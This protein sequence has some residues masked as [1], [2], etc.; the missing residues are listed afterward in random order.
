[1]LCKDKNISIFCLIDNISQ[2]IDH[3]YD[4][5]RQESDSGIILT[6]IVSFTSFYENHSMQSE[7][8]WNTNLLSIDAIQSTSICNC[9]QGIIHSL[10]NIPETL[11]F[12]GKQ[13][14]FSH[15]TVVLD[16]Q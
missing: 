7:Y 9:I 1:M 8:R 6:T 5:R 15:N 16:Y 13:S 2:V 10:Y 11:I 12:T 4:I 14:F 3:K